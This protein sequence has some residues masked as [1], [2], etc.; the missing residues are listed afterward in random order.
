[1]ACVQT[2]L[3]SDLLPEGTNACVHILTFV[4]KSSFSFFSRGI[5]VSLMYVCSGD[6]CEGGF[7]PNIKMLTVF[8]SW[9]HI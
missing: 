8:R 3:N 5:I 2:N 6:H 4:F 9:I 1:M 7:V